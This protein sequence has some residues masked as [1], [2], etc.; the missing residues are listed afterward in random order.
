MTDEFGAPLATN[1]ESRVRQASEAIRDLANDLKPAV[2]GVE[3]VLRRITDEL[4][5]MTRQAPL[6]SLVVAFVLG[7]MF[8][9]KRR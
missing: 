6:Q 3:P 1:G 2:E 8:A 5:R 4:Y 7:M 9:R